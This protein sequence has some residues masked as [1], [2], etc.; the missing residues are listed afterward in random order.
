MGS[1]N[2]QEDAQEFYSFLVNAIHEELLQLGND[3]DAVANEPPSEWHEVRKG[4]K[5]SN[6]LVV[7][8]VTFHD[9]LF[10]NT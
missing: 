4:N 10:N 3:K 8:E 1:E 7:R 6:L 9:I 5:T 2:S